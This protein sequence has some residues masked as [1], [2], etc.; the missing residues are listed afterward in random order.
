LLKPDTAQVWSYLAANPLMRGFVLVGGTALAMHL[1]H[2]VSEDLDFMIPDNKLPRQ[3]I[4]AL[5]RAAAIHGYPFVANDSVAGVREFEDTGLDYWDYMQDFIVN[6]SVKLTLVAPDP[7]V[8][9]LLLPGHD[10]RPRVASLPE[11]F[12]LKCIACANRSKSRDWLDMYLMLRNGLFQPADFYAAFEEAGVPMKF[13]IA[14]SRMCAG[15]IPASDEGY[16]TL[17]ADPPDIPQMQAFFT[18]IKTKIEEDVAREKA[19][20]LLRRDMNL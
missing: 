16:D 6:A 3:R 12:K 10:D 9:R 11:I 17:L 4:E 1:N 5:K 13:D 19:E 18:E 20:V 15:T 14:M 2:R 8:R 7:E